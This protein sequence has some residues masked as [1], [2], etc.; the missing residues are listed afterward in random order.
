MLNGEEIQTQPIHLIQI[1]IPLVQVRGMFQLYIV[2]I[3]PHTKKENKYTV[4]V[5][6]DISVLYI[7]TCIKYI[8]INMDNLRKKSYKV[9]VLKL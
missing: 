1:G 7:C 3:R 5:R 8:H 2:I 6:N 4:A 9:C